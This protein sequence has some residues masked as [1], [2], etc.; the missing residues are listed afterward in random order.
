MSFWFGLWLSLHDSTIFLAAPFFLG[1]GKGWAC[2]DSRPSPVGILTSRRRI[3]GIDDAS[4]HGEVA[5]EQVP[6]TIPAHTL[7]QSALRNIFE[8]PG[9][10][11]MRLLIL[12]GRCPD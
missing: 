10:P 9:S 3:D 11:R 5:I 12:P 4:F 8:H 7:L 1:S 2:C 6:I